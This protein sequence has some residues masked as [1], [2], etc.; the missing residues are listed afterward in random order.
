MLL[1]TLLMSSTLHL[2]H[3]PLKEPK[4]FFR[5]SKLETELHGARFETGVYIC[6]YIAR[7]R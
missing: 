2:V 6:D 4:V 5:F 1:L 3:C 7:Y